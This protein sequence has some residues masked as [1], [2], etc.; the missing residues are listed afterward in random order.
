[1][2]L[3]FSVQ[4]EKENE[5]PQV[6]DLL[7]R[8]VGKNS[9][10]LLTGDLGAGKTTFSRYFCNSFGLNSVQSP[11]YAIHQHYENSQVK[12]DH[13][14]LYRLE[15]E[16][17]IESTGFYDLLNLQ[18]DYKLV[19]WADKIPI[20]NFPLN[21]SIYELSFKKNDELRLLQL[22]AHSLASSSNKV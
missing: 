20:E 2:K 19:E 6:V 18:S 3:I 7:R 21:S 11:T 15:S 16:A 5:L 9:I 4:I 12:I 8:S 17:D 10:L 1:M 13:F 14:D 22:Y